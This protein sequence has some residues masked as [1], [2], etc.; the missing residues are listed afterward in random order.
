VGFISRSLAIAKEHRHLAAYLSLRTLILP[1]L[2]SVK[3]YN[4][5]KIQERSVQDASPKVGL[6]CKDKIMHWEEGDPLNPLNWPMSVRWV[7]MS[8]IALMTFSVKFRA[9]CVELKTRLTE[10][11]A[12]VTDICTSYSG[13][14][15]QS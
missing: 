7:H 9:R 10:Q 4:V 6:E 15:S 3:E 8:Y 5:E 2:D 14:V 11:T 12:G 13:R 1:M